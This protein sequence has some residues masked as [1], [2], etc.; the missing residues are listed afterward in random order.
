MNICNIFRVKLCFFRVFC[1][2]LFTI[3]RDMLE[4]GVEDSIAFHP[5][6]FLFLLPYQCNP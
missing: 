2:K 6:A 4:H 3:S 1:F 5:L